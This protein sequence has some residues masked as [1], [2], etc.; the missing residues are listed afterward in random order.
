MTALAAPPAAQRPVPWTRLAW[1]TA[2]QHRVALIGTLAL[3]GA[4]S[5]YLLVMGLQIRSAYA[6]GTSCRPAGSAACAEP[7][8]L[9]IAGYYSTAQ[10]MCGLLPAVPV[11][12]L[13]GLGESHLC[14]E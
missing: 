1:V 5:L 8:S 2:R 7:R 12:L 10:V 13:V 14:A 9:F 11:L 6:G 4:L 3:L